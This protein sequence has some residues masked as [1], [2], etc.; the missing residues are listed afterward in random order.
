MRGLLKVAPAL[1]AA[2]V[3]AG[4]GC[5]GDGKPAG[6]EP[7]PDDQITPG[8]NAD[9]VETK[10]GVNI[11]MVFAD[12]GVL[13]IGCIR[14]GASYSDSCRT[15]FEA[16]EMPSHRVRLDSFCIGKYPI[17]QRQWKTVMGDGNNPSQ[18]TGDDLPVDNIS[19][20]DAKE[21]IDK[22]NK[23]TGKA[24]RL[25]TN[26]EWEYAA[27]GGTKSLGYKYSGGNDLGDVAWYK[28]NSDDRTWPA[29]AKKANE[30]GIYDMSGN[31]YEW[32]NDW[33]G[34]YYQNQ[35]RSPIVNPP[36]PADGTERV[37][38]GGCFN[39]DARAARSSARARANPE[40][41]SKMYGVRIAVTP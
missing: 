41:A 15:T 37:L 35:D 32:V 36:G 22:L 3:L 33:H 4:W 21:F 13:T 9:Y 27:R 19:W 18:F 38:R 6:T 34:N 31:I 14:D 7:G 2:A 20:N 26:A 39:Q 40:T 28:D 29:G 5:Q 11:S 25:P 12:G 23:L 30:L 24:Y 1:F 16:A 10:G 17:T 8:G